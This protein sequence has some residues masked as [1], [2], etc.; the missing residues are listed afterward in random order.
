MEILKKMI[1]EHGTVR[2]NN[3][4]MVDSFLNH[5]LDISLL[6]EIGKEFYERF[7]HKNIN[8][9]LTIEAS[10][11]AI[12]AI[13]AQYFNV[14]VVFA[15]KTISTNL[16]DNTYESKVYSFT[17]NETYTVRVAKKF[18][19]KEDKILIIDDF[20]ANGK[21][22]EGL[23]DIIDQANAKIEGIGIVIEKGFQ[24]G[25]K[26]IRD[27]GFNLESLVIIDDI[28]SNKVVFRNWFIISHYDSSNQNTRIKKKKFL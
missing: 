22:L 14:D 1:L 10:G 2:G 23:I 3:I 6:N 8:K 12:A 11:I 17:K 21:A 7:K 4:V 16:D 27:R 9:I 19:D 15:K 13:T 18:L 25:G 20:L 28:K 26:L 24:D 5:K